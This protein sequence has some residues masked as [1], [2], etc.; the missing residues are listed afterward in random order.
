MTSN[1]SDWGVTAD[2]HNVQRVTLHN[3]G[4]SAAIITFG[5]S[6]QDLRIEKHNAPLVLGFDD[7]ESYEKHDLYFGAIAGRCAN[8]I[9]NGQFRLA[10]EEYLLARADGEIHQLHGGPTG[11]AN[12]IWKVV[13]STDFQVVL[14]LMSPAG[15]MGYPGDLIARCSYSLDENGGLIIAL[16]AETGAPTI[17]N[18]TNHAYFNLEDGGANDVN[19][20]RLQI[21]AEE[22]CA[23]TESQVP[24]GELS[25]VSGTQ[26]DFRAIRPIGDYHAYDLNFCIAKDRR[27]LTNVARLIA[28]SSGVQMDVATTEPGIQLFT[29]LNPV[30]A[31]RGLEGIDYVA[32][33]GLCLEAQIWPDAINYSHFPNVILM[34]EQTLRQATQYRFSMTG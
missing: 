34:P 20:H 17:C 8:R 14:E 23:L 21:D 27:E 12:R 13:E 5:A 2:G 6:L 29:A 31:M 9:A 1:I 25:S 11:F 24:T 4:M 30:S 22:V 33:A 15:E 16:E 26:N 10:G 28:P 32:G 19:L 3:N 18:M 7:L